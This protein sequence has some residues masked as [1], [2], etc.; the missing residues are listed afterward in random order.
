MAKEDRT[1]MEDELRN[2]SGYLARGN[3]AAA[4]ICCRQV[5]GR[6]SGHPAALNI[7]GIVA[8]L[9][10]LPNAA[11]VYF[12]QACAAENGLRHA[13]DN[14]LR[15]RRLAAAQVHGEPHGERFLLIKAWGYGFWSDVN[16]VLG[17]LLLAEITARIPV[18]HWGRNSRFT[19]GSDRDA[20]EFYFQPVSEYS[21]EDLYLLEN[22]VFFPAKWTKEKL[23]L[24][25]HAK[26]RGCGSRLAALYYLNRRETVAVSDFYI[27]VVD[28]MPWIPRQHP[29]HGKS[30][31]EAYRFLTA[32]YLRPRES[33][34]A[35]VND[36]FEQHIAGFHTIAVHL[37]GSDKQIEMGDTA[38]INRRYLEVL[39]GTLK[40]ASRVFLLTDDA[41]WVTVFRNAYGNRVIVTDCQRTHDDTGIH[42][43]KSADRVA[44]GREIMHDTYLAARADRFIGNG[45]SNVSAMIALLTDWPP[46]NCVL[47]APPVL[48]ERNLRVFVEGVDGPPQICTTDWQF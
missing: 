12:E 30:I 37:R 18:V 25:D 46:D 24:E 5:L 44:L 14:L 2:A 19:D 42:Y 27:G 23:W 28:L 11:I 8:A 35:A 34:L 1:L 16:H 9:L 26:W 6:A 32:K 3:L 47:L 22:P 48:Y 4:D 39:D 15:A 10:G 17:A 31:A 36:F 7:A 29:L 33:I 21:I 45:Q 38:A 20:F 43:S 40:P 13:R 41:R